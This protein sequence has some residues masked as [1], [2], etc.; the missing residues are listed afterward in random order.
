VPIDEQG[1]CSHFTALKCTHQIFIGCL[2][3][4]Q[5]FCRPVNQLVHVI[6]RRFTR[7]WEYFP[8][9]CRFTLFLQF[10]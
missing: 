1:K 8:R 10:G 7:F 3:V 4:L 9:N 2:I 5:S 6:G